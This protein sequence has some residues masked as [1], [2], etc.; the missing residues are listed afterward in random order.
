MQSPEKMAA[1][2]F[3]KGIRLRLKRK[4]VLP[5]LSILS[6]FVFLFLAITLLLSYLT[7][8]RFPILGFQF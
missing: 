1:I 4:N 8:A 7:A 3:K 6:L 5:L 2:K